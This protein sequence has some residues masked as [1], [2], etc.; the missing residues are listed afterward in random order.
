MSRRWKGKS[1][2]NKGRGTDG[3]TRKERRGKGD[4]GGSKG[5]KKVG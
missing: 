4:Q 2:G 3:E 1:K 5:R